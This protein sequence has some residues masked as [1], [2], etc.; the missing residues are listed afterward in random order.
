MSRWDSGEDW[1]HPTFGAAQYDEQGFAANPDEHAAHN[2]SMSEPEYE[3]GENV[4]RRQLN[5]LL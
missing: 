5:S 3:L 4:M 1:H 2:H